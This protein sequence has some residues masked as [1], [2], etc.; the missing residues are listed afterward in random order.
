MG[1]TTTVQT[2]PAIESTGVP[3]SQYTIQQTTDIM[4]VEDML[5]Q[6]EDTNLTTDYITKAAIK[7]V[8]MKQQQ[9]LYDQ[10]YQ[11]QE[12]YEIQEVE[13]QIRKDRLSVE[14]EWLALEVEMDALQTQHGEY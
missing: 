4:Y 7:D 3:L 1:T 6:Q 14:K 2:T 10:S 13:I 11:E 9:N 8:L 12:A 5:I